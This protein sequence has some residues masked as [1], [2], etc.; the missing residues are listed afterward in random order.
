MGGKI[1]NEKYKNS[2]EEKFALGEDENTSAHLKM[3]WILFTCYFCFYFTFTRYTNVLNIVVFMVRKG[4]KSN[5]PTIL[6]PPSFREL[7][8]WIVEKT[9]PVKLAPNLFSFSSLNQSSSLFLKC[10]KFTCQNAS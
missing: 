8:V 9:Y 2:N 3:F 10:C 5:A 7:R 4:K 1:R 6:Y